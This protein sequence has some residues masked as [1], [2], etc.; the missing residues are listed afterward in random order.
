M[1]NPILPNSRH[2]L[3]G[4]SDKTNRNLQDV[5]PDLVSP[6]HPVKNRRPLAPVVK[7]NRPEICPASGGQ[8]PDDT[9][10]NFTGEKI[11]PL[12]LLVP[13]SHAF[14]AV[15]LDLHR[16]SGNWQWPVSG[17]LPGNFILHVTS[18]NGKLKIPSCYFNISPHDVCASA[19]DLELLLHPG[20][21]RWR[22]P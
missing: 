10:Q 20:S 6:V 13:E 22:L 2:P 14:E 16:Q 5:L 11:H 21:G 17:F 4:F 18:I 19:R 9:R 1:T 8:D 7:A 15:A 12:P 3:P